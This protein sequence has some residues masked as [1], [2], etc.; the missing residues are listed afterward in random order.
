[1]VKGSVSMPPF[2]SLGASTS[3]SEAMRFP[4]GSDSMSLGITC[5]QAAQGSHDA[6]AHDVIGLRHSGHCSAANTTLPP[7]FWV[8][9]AF[10]PPPL[11]VPPHAD[12]IRAIANKT[13]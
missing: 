13:A 7:C 12:A 5:S 8:V 4:L 6:L 2:C 9:A 11:L 1:M 3:R 10:P